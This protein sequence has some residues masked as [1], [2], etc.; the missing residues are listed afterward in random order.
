MQLSNIFIIY[1]VYEFYNAFIVQSVKCRSQMR[2]ETAFWQTTTPCCVLFSQKCC[3][4]NSEK[5]SGIVKAG[6]GLK[7]HTSTT[8]S[9]MIFHHW[10]GYHGYSPASHIDENT[11][12]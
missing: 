10:L 2:D 5:T 8:K 1:T 3:R 11:A 6:N 7:L 9:N 12:T 4:W